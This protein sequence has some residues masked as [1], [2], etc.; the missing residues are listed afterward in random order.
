MSNLFSDP[1]KSIPKQTP[2]AFIV[3]VPMD[4]NEIGGRKIPGTG[5]SA[6]LQLSH[7]SK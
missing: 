2:D 3:R 6:K 7:V 1:T 5:P 4:A